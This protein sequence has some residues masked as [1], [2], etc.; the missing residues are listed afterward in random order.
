MRPK[1]TFF[2]LFYANI[3]PSQNFGSAVDSRF[4]NCIYFN[5]RRLKILVFYIS[6]GQR[7]VYIQFIRLNIFLRTKI[8]IK[9]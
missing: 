2:D 4:R 8:A 6:M 5:G 9:S 3:W 1:K 7:V